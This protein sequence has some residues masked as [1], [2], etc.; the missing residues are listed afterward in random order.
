MNRINVSGKLKSNNHGKG[1][2]ILNSDWKIQPQN[3]YLQ[4]VMKYI[5]MSTYEVHTYEYIII[6]II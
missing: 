2:I 1:F 3:F 6:T 4:H 5:H